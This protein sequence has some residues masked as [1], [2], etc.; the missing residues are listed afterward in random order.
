MKFLRNCVCQ[1]AYQTDT[2]GRSKSFCLCLDSNE[3]GTN[4]SF[5]G[6][7]LLHI[8]LSTSILRYSWSRLTSI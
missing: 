5:P 2:F 6:F 4:R 1:N 8:S 7:R 3:M